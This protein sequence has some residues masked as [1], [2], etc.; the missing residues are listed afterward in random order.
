MQGATHP[1]IIK[2]FV[3]IV[4]PDRMNNTLIKERAGHSRRRVDFFRRPR[5]QPPSIVDLAG[6]QR[7]PHIGGEGGE[8]VELDPIEVGQPLIPILG[9][10]LHDPDLFI[11]P[12]LMPERA[13][14]RKVHHLTQV[15]VMVLKRLLA[16][17]NIPPTGKRPQHEIRGTGLVEREFNRLSVADV[18]S[19]HRREQRSARTAKTLGRPDDPRVGGLNIV[20]GQWGA[21]VKVH[22]FPE[23]KGVGLAIRGNLPTV[24]EV[25]NDGLPTVHWIPSDQVIVHTALS[26]HVGHGPRLVHIKMRW[27]T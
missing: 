26:S 17:N 21:V 24:R 2:R 5:V 20:R 22:A 1:G 10:A 12:F 18:D 7:A 15:V 6:Q 13:G 16:H 23:E 4:H 9:V 11:D 3:L 25:W 8:M 19:A 27:R 14:T